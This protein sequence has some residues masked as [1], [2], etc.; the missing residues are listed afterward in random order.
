VELNIN[1]P[2]KFIILTFIQDTQS[3]HIH[4]T[5]NYLKGN[6]NVFSRKL[7]NLHIYFKEGRDRIA[8]AH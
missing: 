1:A 7:K 3:S 4:M 5:V 8:S 2:R 6:T